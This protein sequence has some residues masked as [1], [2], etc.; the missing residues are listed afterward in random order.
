M[1]LWLPSVDFWVR[2]HALGEFRY[3]V[4]AK[5]WAAE[6]PEGVTATKSCGLP[7]PLFF[8][9]GTLEEIPLDSPI[10]AAFW[11]YLTDYKL[12]PHLQLFSSASDLVVQLLSADFADLSAKM[13]R[14]N[15]QTWHRSS[16][17]YQSA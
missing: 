9:S 14:F 8:Q 15:E 3:S 2:I 13:A 4:F 1:P 6:L 5:R 17:F 11:F 12:F 7:A 10:T 16:A